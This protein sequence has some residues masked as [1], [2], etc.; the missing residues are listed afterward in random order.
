MRYSAA[1]PKSRPSTLPPAASS[2][3]SS[4]A[5][6]TH[7]SATATAIWRRPSVIPGFG[8]TLGFTLTYLSLI[9]LIPLAALILRTTELTWD[10]FWA[11]ATDPRVVAALRVSFGASLLAATINALFGLIV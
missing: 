6:R 2:T 10:Q 9:V 4:S 8:M 7:M 11:I 3:R 5:D 1:G